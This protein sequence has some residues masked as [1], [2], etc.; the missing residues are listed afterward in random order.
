MDGNFSGCHFWV[1][2]T[3]EYGYILVDDAGVLLGRNNEGL[4]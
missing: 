3:D 1:E 4:F 2:I